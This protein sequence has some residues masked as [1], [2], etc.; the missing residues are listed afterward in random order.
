MGWLVLVSHE[1]VRVCVD[2]LHDFVRVCFFCQLFCLRVL[3][4][5][6]FLDYLSFHMCFFGEVVCVVHC[7]V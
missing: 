4:H 6:R 5:S 1:F 2:V 3:Y 7:F